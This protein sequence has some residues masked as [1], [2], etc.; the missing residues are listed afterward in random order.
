MYDVLVDAV[1]E[2]GIQMDSGGADG[3][4][5]VSGINYLYE[6][7]YGDLSGWM[8]RVNGEIPSVSCDEY[9]L[10]DGDIVEWLYT[11]N[12]GNDLQ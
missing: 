8:Y 4:M 11:C 1:R 9:M 2:N 5:Y 10:S 12:L 6:F 3:M 7:D